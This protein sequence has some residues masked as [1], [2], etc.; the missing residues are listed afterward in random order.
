M[1][2]NDEKNLLKD[3]DSLKRALPEIMKLSVI[4][5]ELQKIRDEK[6]VLSSHLDSVKLIIDAK[7]DEIQ[8][9]KSKSQGQRDKQS[10][11]RDNA[12][13]FTV[14]IDKFSEDI[15]N[16]YQTKDQ[17]RESYFKQLYEF[18]L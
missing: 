17:M 14:L 18:E 15:R 1:S 9:T 6:K 8:D 7:E 5:P 11:V 2:N 16:V 3:I 10:E 12:D 13:K 4:E